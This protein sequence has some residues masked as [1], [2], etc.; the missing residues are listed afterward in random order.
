MRVGR[1]NINTYPFKIPV[2]DPLTMYID[3]PFGGI[4]KL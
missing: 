2:D 3:Q 4:C 1:P